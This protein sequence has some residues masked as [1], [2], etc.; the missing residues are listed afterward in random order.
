VKVNGE[1]IGSLGDGEAVWHT[2][3]SYLDVPPK[4][5]MLYALEVPPTGGNTSFC[6]MYGVYE[7]LPQALKDRVAGLKIKHDG[8]YNS[9]GY[10]RQGVTPTDDP[11]QA[12][13]AWHPAVCA[14]P[15]TGVAT[16][17]LGR[18][19]TSYVE[20]LAPAESETLLDELWAQATRDDFAYAHHWRV[21]DLLLWDNRSTMHRRDPFDDH[22]RRVMHRTQ[23]KGRWAPR[24]YADSERAA[25]AT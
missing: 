9:G 18:R 1:P 16:L 19:R 2:D 15:V 3:M 20:G 22:T 10:V 11:H 12:P 24:P 25:L 23:I 5:S 8:T 6:T 14:H 13:G 4:A 21:G 7:A 17:Y